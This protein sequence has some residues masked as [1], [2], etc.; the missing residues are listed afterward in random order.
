MLNTEGLAKNS[1]PCVWVEVSEELAEPG[2]IATKGKFYVRFDKKYQRTT[3]EQKNTQ[4]TETRAN[5][6]KVLSQTW[7]DLV[8]LL[9]PQSKKI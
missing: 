6:G 7:R 9:G 5:N 8:C 2:E 1:D 3:Q 4:T